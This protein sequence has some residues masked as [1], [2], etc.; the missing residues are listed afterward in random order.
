M[1]GREFEADAA[2]HR[3]QRRLCG[4]GI[5]VSGQDPLAAG[6]NQPHGS[7]SW[8]DDPVVVRQPRIG[9]AGDLFDS[10]TASGRLSSGAIT[11]TISAS[12]GRTDSHP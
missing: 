8:A 2:V 11:A 9:A 5:R 12:L 1:S 6:G 7:A 3:G 10:V 4:P